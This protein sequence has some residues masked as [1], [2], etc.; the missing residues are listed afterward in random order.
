[1]TAGEPIANLMNVY[2]VNITKKLNLTTTVSSIDCDPYL[3]L[4]FN[5]ISLKKIKQIYPEIVPNSFK[6]WPVT[7]EDLKRKN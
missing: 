3:D 6:S 4:F 2:F 5:H 1:M 7:E